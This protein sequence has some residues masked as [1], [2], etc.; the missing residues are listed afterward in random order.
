VARFI[1]LFGLLVA[2][3]V[4]TTGCSNNPY[5]PGQSAQ[6]VRYLS[7][8]NDL[9]TMDPTTSYNEAEGVVIDNIYECYFRYNH[10]KVKPY[11]V[12]LA[13]GAAEPTREKVT[14][15]APDPKTGKM[16][17]ITGEQWTFH[18]KK[19]LRFQ[20]DPCFPGGH[21]RG[22][23]AADFV[24]SWRRMADPT[25]N[26]PILSFVQDKVQGLDA[27][28]KHNA[29]LAKAKKPADYNYPLPGVTVDPTDPYSFRIRLVQPYPQL[30]YLMTMH[31]TTPVWSRF[32]AS[33]GRLR[34]FQD[35]R[36]FTQTTNHSGEK[37]ESDV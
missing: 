7:W 32:C 21:G 37:P 13:L 8:S 31:F 27:L 24:Y 5:P 28:V 2:A 26:C 6:R 10:L 19:G 36:V 15:S 17:S 33:S 3:L 35:D 16:V 34:H 23:T 1:A 11:V 25:L 9:R 14:L 30:R 18:I 12:E 22:I 29:D 20:D 4:S